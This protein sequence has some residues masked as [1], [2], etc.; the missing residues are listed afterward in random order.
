M[1]LKLAWRNIWRNKKRTFITMFSII[2]AVVL[3]ILLDSVKK[4]LLD[5]MKENVVSFY[6]GYIQVHK[7]GYWDDR[8]L[9]NSFELQPELINNT[10]GNKGIS[11]V[12]PRLES[13]IMAASDKY[14]KGCMVVGIDP[15]KE[16]M[17]TALDKKLLKGEY[18]QP[19]DKAVLVTE[20]LANY[21]KLD[22]N[23]TLV[24]IGQGYHGVSAAGKYPIKGL[25]KFGSPEL[26]KGL[27]YL[28]LKES[29]HLFAADNKLTALVISPTNTDKSEEMAGLLAETLGE[30]YEVMNWQL[31]MP[32]LDQVIQGEKR[33]NIVFQVVLYMLIAFGIF[34]TILMMTLER[35]YEFGVM[36][37]IGMKNLRLSTMV[38]MENILISTLGAVGGI[39]LSV[40][41]VFYLFVYPIRL[42]GKLA[43]A[44]E[45]FGIEPIFYFSIAPKVFYSQGLVV[46]FLAL[47]LSLYPFLKIRRLNP[48]SA[49]QG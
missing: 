30:D 5:K 11:R 6:T 1:L 4:G 31:M 35:Q 20:G 38:I 49:M 40:P 32:E 2:F 12:I 7:N 19:L 3:S 48:V 13:F 8:T 28:P 17:V 47:F 43:E 22:V 37:A 33:E 10:E 42:G 25:V 29:Q 16:S 46:F 15:E 24:M 21:L 41:I 45:K 36:V 26:N 27:V 9:E 39:L 23:D 18:L 34:G 14:S 44:Y